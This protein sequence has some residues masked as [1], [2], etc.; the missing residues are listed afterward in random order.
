MGALTRFEIMALRG[1]LLERLAKYLCELQRD[2][3][4]SPGV[5]QRVRDDPQL[6]RS[7]ILVP[8]VPRELFVEW[9]LEF[10]TDSFR[11]SPAS[12]NVS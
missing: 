4:P 5:L 11:R 8:V 7:P 10:A 9:D 2:V 1:M 12:E 6:S 3:R